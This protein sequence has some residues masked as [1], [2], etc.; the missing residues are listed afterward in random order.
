MPDALD[1]PLTISAELGPAGAVVAEL[2]DRVRAVEFERAAER[3]PWSTPTPAINGETAFPPCSHLA[4]TGTTDSGR[5][6]YSRSDLV[7]SSGALNVT[8]DI[9]VHDM[10]PPAP[11]GTGGWPC[12]G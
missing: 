9:A 12:L 10:P 1:L 11:S 3:S 5:C 7:V 2:H 4:P 8:P 6:Q